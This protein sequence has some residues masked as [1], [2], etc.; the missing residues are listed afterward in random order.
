MCVCGY[1]YIY[2][3]I[4]IYLDTHIHR[5]RLEEIDATEESGGRKAA[6]NG[7]TA[8]AQVHNLTHTIDANVRK[9]SRDD[10]KKTINTSTS[11]LYI[12]PLHQVNT[13]TSDQ[14]GRLLSFSGSPGVLD[15]TLGGTSNGMGGA[16]NG[17]MG[18]FTVARTNSGNTLMNGNGHASG[19]L[20][21]VGTPKASRYYPGRSGS[22]VNYGR[23]GSPGLVGDTLLSSAVDSNSVI[24][25]AQAL[26]DR[27]SAPS[28]QDTARVGSP[29]GAW[30]LLNTP[31]HRNT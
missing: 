13:S 17:H 10:A 27:V 31:Q 21:P 24:R 11:D 7:Q 18:S 15:N 8:L 20:S 30:S 14:S 22:P 28:F 9:L 16:V 4:Y 6:D 12:R 26:L 25:S 5:S 1:L 23:P 29:M 2:I 19:R 3:Y